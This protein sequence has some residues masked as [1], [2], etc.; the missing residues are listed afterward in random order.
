[1]LNNIFKKKKIKIIDFSKKN[2]IVFYFFLSFQKKKKSKNAL[3]Y[4]EKKIFYII[5]WGLGSS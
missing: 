3:K 5:L 2:S 1:M 4:S